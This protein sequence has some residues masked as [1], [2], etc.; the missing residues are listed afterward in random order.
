MF[1]VS[2]K[3]GEFLVRDDVNKAGSRSEKWGNEKIVI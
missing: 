1:Y 2:K 3:F